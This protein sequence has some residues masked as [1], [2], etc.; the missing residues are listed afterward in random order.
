MTFEMHL[1]TL[2]LFFLSEMIIHPNKYYVLAAPNGIEFHRTLRRCRL[3]SLISLRAC[4]HRWLSIMIIDPRGRVSAVRWSVSSLAWW[5]SKIDFSS[6]RACAAFSVNGTVISSR[7]RN[8]PPAFPGFRASRFPTIDCS[9]GF[10]MNS[11]GT[12]IS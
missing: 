9:S 12:M 4:S 11:G 7:N 6:S 8:R 10:L 5:L 1:C 2:N 3:G